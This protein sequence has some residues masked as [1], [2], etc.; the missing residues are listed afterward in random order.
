VF[1]LF[2]YYLWLGFILRII[3]NTQ[4]VHSLNKKHRISLLKWTVCVL[5]P[6]P[7]SLTTIVF[8][9]SVPAKGPRWHFS[10]TVP[11]NKVPQYRPQY[12]AASAATLSTM[13]CILQAISDS[14]G[15]AQSSE[16]TGPAMAQAI[17]RRPV[18][19][20]TRFR[21]QAG[22]CRI[23]VDTVAL[24]RVSV[25]VM[26]VSPCHLSSLQWYKAYSV[27]IY[28]CIYIYIVFQSKHKNIR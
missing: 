22:L 9:H 19:T 3:C 7:E 26:R 2:I 11:S 23:V 13:Q 5:I 15:R 28:V 16:L 21:S 14:S 24:G 1:D 6:R 27:Y 8:R 17:S 20:Q 4:K 12:A 18:T 25:W 10:D